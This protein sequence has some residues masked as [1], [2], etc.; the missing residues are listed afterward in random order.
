MK[1][2][3]NEMENNIFGVN[4]RRL[5]ISKGLSQTKLS[6]LLGLHRNSIGNYERGSREPNFETLVKI[7]DFFECSTD[8]ILR[9]EDFDDK[10]V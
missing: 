8:E 3:T 4:L 1:E 6:Q 5:R 10:K 9:R 7:A 2:R